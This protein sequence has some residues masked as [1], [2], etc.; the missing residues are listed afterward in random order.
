[1]RVLPWMMLCL[2]ICAF[3]AVHPAPQGVEKLAAYAGTWKTVIHHLDTPY[4]KAGTES[5]ILKNDCW[6]SS[7]FLACN[8]IVDG[9]S[10]AL[11]VFLYDAASGKYSSYP[12]PAGVTPDVSPGSL[13]IDGAIWIFPWNITHDGKTT[14]FRVRN[15]WSS[16]DSIEYHQEYSLDGSHWISMAEGHETRIKP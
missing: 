3:A 4:S 7:G 2:P 9:D 14:H 1:M 16:K 8:Q 11:I 10:K 5:H 13:V 6:R 15:F 12:I